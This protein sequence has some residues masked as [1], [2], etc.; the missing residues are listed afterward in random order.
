MSELIFKSK[1]GLIL[2]SLMQLAA[3]C[4]GATGW[5]KPALKNTVHKVK[6]KTNKV[7]HSTMHKCLCWLRWTLFKLHAHVC[8]LVCVRDDGNVLASL[9]SRVRTSPVSHCVVIKLK[10][11][12]CHCAVLNNRL[13]RG[14][15][16]MGKRAGRQLV[17]LVESAN[18]NLAREMSI[19]CF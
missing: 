2:I 18:S 6:K 5:D 10:S 16:T 3:T 14:V 11:S 8:T 13:D 1:N 7:T 4:K 15:L 19:P 17:G 9:M 12:I